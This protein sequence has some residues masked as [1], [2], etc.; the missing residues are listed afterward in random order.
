MTN[1][2]IIVRTFDGLLDHE[3]SLVLYGRAAIA[4]GFDQAPEVVGKSMDVDVILRFS[5]A[6]KMDADDQFW[7]AQE[8]VNIVLKKKGLYMTH[9][10]TE[11]QVFLRRDWERH[12]MPVTSITLRWLKLFR[13]ATLDLILTKMMR[14][15]DAE[16]MSDIEFM[17]RHDLITYDQVEEALA[18]VVIPDVQELRDAFEKARPAVLQIAHR[19]SCV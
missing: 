11:A 17:I 13:P 10:F 16:D 1:A 2:E 19:I 5:D 6:A 12:I 8:E 3:A 4:L 9:M 18:N 15:N 7:N 14:G